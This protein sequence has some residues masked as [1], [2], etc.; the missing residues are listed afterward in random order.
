M[1]REAQQATVHAVA[2]SRTRLKQLSPRARSE[3]RKPDCVCVGR[4][5]GVC[6]CTHICT[7]TY[8]H[9]HGH[10]RALQRVFKALAAPMPQGSKC[11]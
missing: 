7:H 9:A 5:G 11:I 8:S 3:P 10:L 4:G 2:K 6:L 1:N